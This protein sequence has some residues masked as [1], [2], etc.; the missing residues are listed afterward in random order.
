MS[1]M[2]RLDYNAW[3]PMLRGAMPPDK[4]RRYKSH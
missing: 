2:K 1:K 4:P 3:A